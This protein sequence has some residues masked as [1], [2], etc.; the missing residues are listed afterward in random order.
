MG[1]AVKMALG[2]G[3]LTNTHAHRH[4]AQQGWEMVYS[5]I[6]QSASVLEGGS[7]DLDCI[8]HSITSVALSSSSCPLPGSS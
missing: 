3:Y 6:T 1:A 2:D 7:K 8:V 5:L 4:Y